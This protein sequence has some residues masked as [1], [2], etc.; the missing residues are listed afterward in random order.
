[1]KLTKN[2]WLWEWVPESIYIMPGIR[3][4]WFVDPDIVNLWQFVR[5]RYGK[6]VSINTWKS[7]GNLEQ[8]GF[9]PPK[10][11]TGA[12]LSDHRFGRAGDGSSE[13]FTPAELRADIRKN[14]ALYYSKGLRCVEKDTP[15]WSHL[16]TRPRWNK[17]GILWVRYK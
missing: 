9:R 13:A 12:S 1:M 2:F 3:P 7:G 10:S 14:S 8:R 16:S 15:T 6:P 17:K 11:R 4:E 5:D